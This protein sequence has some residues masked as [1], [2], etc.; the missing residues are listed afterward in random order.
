M[1]KKNKPRAD[2]RTAV[3]VELG[4]DPETGRRIRKPCYGK[5]QAEA[6]AK[7]DAL[8]AKLGRGLDV[9]ASRD[10]FSVWAARWLERKSTVGGAK[11]HKS[12]A[13]NIGR[14]NS[15]FGH[16]EIASVRLNDIQGM[17]DRLAKYNPYTGKPT[18][19]RTLAE[20]RNVA[21]SVFD[22]AILNRVFEF[23]PAAYVTIPKTAATSTKR[24]A[25]TDEEKRWVETTSHRAQA[26]AMIMLYAGLRRG[27]LVALQWSDIDIDRKTIRVTKSAEIINNR[28]VV[29]D[30][31]KTIAG[32]RTVDMPQKL[33][34]YLKTVPKTSLFISSRKSGEMHTEASWRRMWESYM[35]EV[36]RQH[37]DCTSL[38]GKPRSKY[39]NKQSV[40]FVIE[41]FTPHELRHTFAS[42]LYHT[43]A[44]VLTAVAEA[45]HADPTIT[46][47]IYTHLDT[48]HKRKS[49][50][51][52]H[53]GGVA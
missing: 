19:R 14:L 24:R 27:E 53:Y 29:K 38:V 48:M 46:L 12:C 20:L 36:N 44:D 42:L 35:N 22:Y 9:N 4:R 7:A 52:A 3:Y 39:D 51:N 37:G 40:P 45:G 49:M 34:D 1:K 17:F 28:F 41:G 18:S 43:G 5:T 13:A 6:D 11:W 10:T 47:R 31:A 2:G 26:A 30:G 15:E 32:T 23:N 21:V 16:Y 33:A 25:L 8:K 50:A